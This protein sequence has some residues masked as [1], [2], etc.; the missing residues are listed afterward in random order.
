[1]SRTVVDRPRAS[2][3][4]IAACW[5][6]HA[7]TASGAVAALAALAAVAAGR[8]AE[9]FGW[10]YLAAVIDAT[11]GS[12]ARAARV[13]DYLPEV[14]GA[15]LDDLV[16]F[17][18]FV[19]VPLFLL[20]ETGLLAGWPGAL[21]AA[22]ATLA[23]ACRFCHVEAKTEDHFFTGFPSYWNV[24]ALYFVVYEPPPVLC[25]AI[26]LVLAALV[27]APL[28]FIYPSRTARL[29]SWSVGLGVVWAVA[30]AAILL[31]LPERSPGLATLSLAYPAYYTA[32]S[33]YLDRRR[34]RGSTGQAG[35]PSVAG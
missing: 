19:V 5:A 10:L 30:V 34:R 27:F 16:D 7:Y 28:R 9:A 17:L 22:V 11:D 29:R 24:A 33:V 8:I 20:L 14:D 13:K 23:S 32:V 15:R 21:A 18:T 4:R 12:L 26:T 25:A 2:R 31:R 35:S 3:A 1:M 6:V